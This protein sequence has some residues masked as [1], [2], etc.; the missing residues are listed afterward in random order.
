M[1]K[2]IQLSLA[3]S[4]LS[5]TA[6]Y[7]KSD[8]GTI[9][10]SSATKSEQSIKD[11]TSNIDVITSLEL[12]E[13]NIKTVAEALNLVS[14]ISFT[15]N[16]GMGKTTS[17]MI[18]GFNTKRVLVLIDGMRYNDLTSSSGAP[19]EN[20]LLTNI[21]KIE[22]IKGA[23]S[24]IWGADASAGV[25]N[26]ITKKPKNGLSGTVGAEFGSFHT[27]IYNG[28]LAYK[29]EKFY[30][31]ASHQRTTTDGFTAY[32]QKGTDIDT[33]EDDGYR[34]KTFSLKGGFN[35]DDNNK[36]DLTH[37]YID[38]YNEFDNTSSDNLQASSTGKIK[39]SGVS[40]ENKNATATSEIKI[41]RSDFYREYPN[42]SSKYDGKVDEISVK[43]NL[44][45][46]DNS[47]FLIAGVDYKKFDQDDLVNNNYKNKAVFATNSNKLNNL[48]FTRSLRYDN[49]DKFDN[50]TT[51][52]I[53]LKYNIF[54]EFTLFSNIGTA[55]NVPSLGQLYGAFGANP[56]LEPESTKSYD[57]GFQYNDIKV[58]YF[59]NTVDNMLD[60]NL[61]T[62]GYENISGKS[63]F[64]GIEIDYSKGIN[65]SNFLS[66][67]YTR[68]SAKNKD[69]EYLK[70]RPNQSLKFGIDNYSIPKLHIGLYG[71]Y[72]AERYNLDDK[73]GTQTGKY[74]LFNLSLNYDFNKA[75]KIYGKIDN[76]TNKYYQVVDNYA[77]SPRAFYAGIKYSF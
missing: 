63:R 21:D 4:L 50:K 15:S 58:T 18:R 52:K 30:F 33:Y 5:T 67:S 73:Q 20:M 36:I 41:S 45:Y 6:I 62:S 13:K 27:R 51:G 32:A 66:L 69:G 57:I 48:T 7:A 65:Q 44:P 29:N 3:A 9:T 39:I 22:I 53:G 31:Q 72:I 60:Y 14:G 19:F 11:V 28:T 23:Q 71:E 34:N 10:V 64:K 49:F 43:T 38:T 35:I 1:K 47:S 76:I 25:I 17:V 42:F 24:G 46:F 56:D 68:L 70:R 2:T 40:Y 16:G 55:Y 37:T 59:Y 61:A 12:E 8:L 74:T 54:E 75:I 77:T 26:I